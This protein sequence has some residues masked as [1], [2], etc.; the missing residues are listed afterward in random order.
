MTIYASWGRRDP[1]WLV[2]IGW[3]SGAPGIEK[4]WPAADH[5]VVQHMVIDGYARK[6]GYLLG[7]RFATQDDINRLGGRRRVTR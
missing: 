7:C 3:D 1:L 6:G 2:T 5:G 4:V